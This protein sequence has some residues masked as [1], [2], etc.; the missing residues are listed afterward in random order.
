MADI[1]TRLR[2]THDDVIPPSDV[3][4]ALATRRSRKARADTYHTGDEGC[5]EGYVRP[6]STAGNCLR[7]HQ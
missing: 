7:L 2:Q 4:G 6:N 1:R 5:D 3:M